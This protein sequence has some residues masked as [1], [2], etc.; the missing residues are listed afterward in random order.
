MKAG[1]FVGAELA[2]VLDE[3]GLV[4]CKW[5]WH[6]V[7]GQELTRAAAVTGECVEVVDMAAGRDVV[8]A[9][10]CLPLRVLPPPEGPRWWSCGGASIPSAVWS[11]QRCRGRR[12]RILP[13][14]A[15]L[16]G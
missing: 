6:A 14:R 7:A 13:A 4:S 12:A 15:R 11:G 2:S 10:F 3:A 5:L 9:E 16:R 8:A 1:L